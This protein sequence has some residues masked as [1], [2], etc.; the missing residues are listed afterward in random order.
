MFDV[1]MSNFIGIFELIV[2][3][4]HD[5][6]GVYGSSF[7]TFNSGWSNCNFQ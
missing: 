3:N 6:A 2:R 5:D 7:G 4:I 1:L